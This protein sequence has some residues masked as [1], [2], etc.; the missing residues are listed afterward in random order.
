MEDDGG[1]SV[2]LGEAGVD[3]KFAQLTAKVEFMEFTAKVPK[4]AMAELGAIEAWL[5]TSLK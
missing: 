5:A 4:G 3:F 2:V 1:S